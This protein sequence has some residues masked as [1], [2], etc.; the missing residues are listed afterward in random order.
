MK[1]IGVANVTAYTLSHLSS[2]SLKNT[3]EGCFS[4]VSQNAS[5]AY[6]CY[7]LQPKNG[8][9]TLTKYVGIASSDAFP[10]SELATA[11]SATKSALDTGYEKLLDEHREAWDALW[12]DS[13][14]VIEGE[15]G[16]QLAARASL[17]HILSNVREG[18]EGHG[19]GDNSIAP[20][21][22]TS[23]SYAGQVFWDADTW[24]F[25]SLL[26]LFP[27]YAQSITNFRSR[28]LGA[29]QENVKA[30][31]RSGAIW[32]W[33]GGRY[34]N[35]TGV[36]P[37]YDYEYHL[38][39]DIALAQWQYWAATQNRTWLQTKGWPVISS[40][41]KFWASQVVPS[42]TTRGKYDTLNETDP[43]EY[44]NFRDNAAFTNAGV[45]VVLRKAIEL[46]GVLGLGKSEVGK[47]GE[48]GE[49]VRV[50]R[51]NSSGI[52]LEYGKSHPNLW[53]GD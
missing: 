8:E 52:V 29:A 2:P 22:L 51:D 30:F 1:P 4:G 42:N 36:G 53:E 46:A 3:T 16:I 38:E 39:N 5:T 40:I 19:L 14:I 32:P 13:D 47:W 33:T 11:L 17:F 28:Q 50:L 12:E 10:H 48:V 18:A 20:A 43:D 27:S 45:S 31:N 49:G 35:C 23:T 21:G 37:C 6:Q 25:P 41:A 34:G 9:F 26:A 7:T 15:D 44:A 24:I